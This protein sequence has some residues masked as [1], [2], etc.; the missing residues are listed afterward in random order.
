MNPIALLFKLL[1][2]FVWQSDDAEYAKTLEQAETWW[3]AILCDDESM[4]S[5]SGK[6]LML[7]KFKRWSTQWYGKVFFAIFYMWSIKQVHTWLND[8]GKDDDEREID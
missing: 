2:R 8:D 7:A 4:K 1:Y 6:D 3:R 5:L